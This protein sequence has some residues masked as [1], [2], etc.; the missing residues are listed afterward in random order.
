MYRFILTYND[1]ISSGALLV[2]L[3][4]K[5]LEVDSYLP[6]LSEIL[7]PPLINRERCV[8]ASE[9]ANGR[10]GTTFRY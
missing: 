1:V 5:I 8:S 3:S 2:G 10:H 7:D 6:P 4:C 9:A